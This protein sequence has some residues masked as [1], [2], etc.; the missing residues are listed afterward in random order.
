MKKPTFSRRVLFRW[1]WPAVL[2]LQLALLAWLTL[3]TPWQRLSDPDAAKVY[4][5]V[6]E[7]WRSGTLVIPQ[8]QQITTLELD[9]ATLFALP[10]YGLT[11]NIGLAFQLADMLCLACVTGLGLGLMRRAGSR[12][13]TA[14]A[15]T[16]LVLLPYSM[17]QLEYWNMLFL[18]AAQY[19]V[20]V[21]LPLLL[22]YLLLPPRSGRRGAPDGA[23]LAVFCA[24]CVCTAFSSGV[25]TAL[26]GLAPVLLY[27]FWLWLHGQSATRWALGCGGAAVACT[28][29]GLAAARLLQVTAKGNDMTLLGYDELASNALNLVQGLFRLMG[30]AHEF[31]APVFSLAGISQLFGCCLLGAL[32]WALVSGLRPALRGQGSPL[33]GYAAALCL[34]N[35]VIL[36]LTNTRYGAPV[37][38]YRYLLIAVVPLFLSLAFQWEALPAAVQPRLHL[39]QRLAPALLVVPLA[40]CMDTQRIRDCEGAHKLDG[41]IELASYIQTLDV[42]TVCLYESSETAELCSAMD[43][44]RSYVSLEGN[45]L[46]SYDFYRSCT[47]ATAFEGR[48][49]LVLSPG[50]IPLEELPV[51]LQQACTYS[52]SPGGYAVYLCGPLPVDGL[53]GLPFGDRMVD[54]CDSPLYTFTGEMDGQ[55]WLHTTTAG[56]VLY[57]AELDLY[58]VTDISLSYRVST[59][60]AQLELWTMDYLLAVTAPIDPQ[61]NTTALSGIP[62]GHYKLRILMPENAEGAFGPLEFVRTAVNQQGS[63]A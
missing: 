11:G 12:W 8:W 48:C 57:S 16:V 52:G 19:V 33:C 41:V 47:D 6:V 22:V 25:Y 29:G 45:R 53:T 59:A 51:Y 24:L 32:G 21:F 13:G 44:Q 2:A 15:A 49:A 35:L 46:R 37:F 54:F 17:G 23:L 26:C 9:C 63:T 20:K 61:A 58:D 55:R 1:F 27:W 28:A 62:P 36:L 14:C 60:G 5:H 56:Y 30:A 7:M 38:E 31:G 3:S 43:L 50:Q 18:N 4:R 42:Q 40:L 10:L 39:L 34:W